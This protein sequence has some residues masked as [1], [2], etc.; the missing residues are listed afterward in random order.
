MSVCI[1]GKCIH[2]KGARLNKYTDCIFASNTTHFYAVQSC[3][4]VLCSPT[5]SV[6]GLHV[7][8]SDN[9]LKVIL[10][11]VI[12]SPFCMIEAA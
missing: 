7:L 3:V 12:Q 9:S 2:N 11:I 5:V 6:D 1:I 4:I 10:V 8:L